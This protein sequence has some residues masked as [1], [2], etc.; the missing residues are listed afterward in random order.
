[1]ENASLL[2]TAKAIL[3]LRSLG[4]TGNAAENFLNLKHGT[5]PCTESSRL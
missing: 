4:L 1:M 5:F 3:C 2:L